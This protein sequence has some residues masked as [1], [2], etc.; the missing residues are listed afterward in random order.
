MNNLLRYVLKGRAEHEYQRRGFYVF[1]K[2]LPP[3]EVQVL[4]D[5]ARDLISY[6]G[7]ILRLNGELSANEF[8]PGTQLV[9][10]SVLNAHLPITEAMKPVHAALRAIITSPALAARLREL[11]GAEHYTIHQTLL[12]FAAQT[13]SLH[14]DS[15]ALDTSPRGFAHTLWIPLQDMDFKSGLPCVIP[16]PQGKVVT[17]AELGWSGDGPYRERYDH[18]QRA[19]SEK[20]L[21]NSPEVAAS[22]VRKGDFV[23]W[24]SLTPH[25][26][27]PSLPFP[28][29]RLSLQVLLRPAHHRWG[30]FIDQP[31]DHL[32]K[33]DIRMT[34]RFSYFIS[35]DF[36]RDYG[37]VDDPRLG[38]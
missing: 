20:L 16:W 32:T 6:P 3:R 35:E 9:R 10:N 12:F 23:V 19:L 17:E 5:S 4:A 37:I 8:F 28:T 7:A 25:F 11:D 36:C 15:W 34:D 26:T 29:E 30:N 24:S 18:Y 14:L 2:A 38:H 13:T 21:A 33:R 31:T 27:L 1:R 22:L